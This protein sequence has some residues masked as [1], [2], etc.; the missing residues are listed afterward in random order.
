MI[1]MNFNRFNEDSDNDEHFEYD[2]EDE[3][4]NLKEE[5]HISTALS[6]K[7]IM[8]LIDEYP[9]LKTI[10]C[11]KSIYNRIPKKYLEV[12][13]KLKIAVKIKYNWGKPVK[14]TEKDRINVINLIKKGLFP[15]NIA[16]RLDIPVQTVYYLKN[17]NKDEQIKLKRGKRKKYSYDIREKVKKLAKDGV[18]IK[19]ISKSENIP[20]RTVYD[21]INEK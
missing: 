6:S 19:K 13:N 18:P 21:I 2:L 11:P 20:L 9:N 14:Y 4:E 8:E 10:T 12:L 7:K 17:K 5:V 3:K 1:K 16:K 15:Q